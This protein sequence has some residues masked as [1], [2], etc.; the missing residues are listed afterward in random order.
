MSKVKVAEVLASEIWK[1]LKKKGVSPRRSPVGLLDNC[2]FQEELDKVTD[3]N[4]VNCQRGALKGISHLRN[5]KNL[6][7]D[8]T[9]FHAF[10]PKRDGLS[11]E[12]K[13]IYEIEELRK[14]NHLSL[15]NQRDIT[16]LD[17]SKLENLQSLEITRCENLEEVAG[18]AE[19]RL[20]SDLTMYG[21]NSL[22]QIKDLDSFIE[23]NQ[24]LEHL[25]LDV[26]LYPNA[27]GYKTMGEY[28]KNAVTKLDFIEPKWSEDVI[29]EKTWINHSQ[30]KKMHK[31]ACEITQEIITANSLDLDK[32]IAINEYIARNIK[33]NDPA[34]DKKF[35]GVVKNGLVIG[36]RLGANG[37][38]DGLINN[39]CVCEGY[40]RVMQYLLTLAGIKSA[41]AYC[42][43]GKDT[44]GFAEKDLEYVVL[45]RD[46]YHSICRIEREGGIY[47]CDPCWNAGSFQS[48]GDST[49]WLLLSKK[50]I[51]E[52]HTLSYNEQNCGHQSPIPKEIINKAKKRI[53]HLFEGKN[54][55]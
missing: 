55:N 54:K 1:E 48:G 16:Q 19:N 4:L 40:T 34:L 39:T 33:Y 11:L 10:Q 12:D 24:K 37:A 7:I 31:K 27:I 14:L 25:E 13:D 5:L 9:T 20:L 8:N 32:I 41:N 23:E 30:M 3:L 42:I 6:S 29:R 36:P 50:Q 22:S 2:F 35:R 18:L 26:L 28:N 46:G 45:P 21:L 15:N 47:Y 49:K 17:I 44:D 38:Y 43:A 53:L 52:S 51:A